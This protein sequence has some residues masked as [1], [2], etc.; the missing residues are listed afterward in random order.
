MLRLF[1]IAASEVDLERS[2]LLFR[3]AESGRSR[4][5]D[6]TR[7][8]KFG[9]DAGPAGNPT[10]EARDAGAAGNP[11]TDARGAG[12][13]AAGNPIT[14][15]RGAG[16]G[17]AGNPTTD[18]RGPDGKPTTDV[19]GCAGENGSPRVEDVDRKL[20]ADEGDNFFT[21]ET[22]EAFKDVAGVVVGDLSTGVKL[23]VLDEGVRL[24]DCELSA[25]VEVDNRNRIDESDR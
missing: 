10:T 24:L 19:R 9:D 23:L 22:G 1:N 13:S 21:G 6:R 5:I 18:I 4:F 12:A 7:L 8:N 2:N 14:E 17:A 15:A 25:S 3:E 16:A 11:T 20:L